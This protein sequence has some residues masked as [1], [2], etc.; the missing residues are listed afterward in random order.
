MY[1]HI[2]EYPAAIDQKLKP[3]RVS[4]PAERAKQFDSPEFAR[5]DFFLCPCVT[6]IESPHKTQLNGGSPLTNDFHH[7]C[8]FGQIKRDRLFAEDGLPCPSGHFDQSRVCIGRSYNHDRIDA[9]MRNGT[10]NFGVG[11]LCAGKNF[12]S[13]RR[14]RAR[15]SDCDHLHL[16]EA[17]NIPQMCFAHPA[18]ADESDANCFPACHSLVMQRL[19]TDLYR[20]SG[21]PTF[22]CGYSDSQ[23]LERIE[24][25]WRRCNTVGHTSKEGLE[26][27]TE[28]RSE[29]IHKEMVMVHLISRFRIVP[30]RCLRFRLD[31]DLAI[32]PKNFRHDIVA[33]DCP[34]R[35]LY[36]ADRA[37]F[38]SQQRCRS[39][40]IPE[41]GGVF[42]E[43]RR[44]PGVDFGD[45]SDQEPGQVEFMNRLIDKNPATFRK[46]FF[47]RRTGV[48]ADRAELVN[49]S[50]RSRCDSPLRFGVSRIKTSLKSDLKWHPVR[51]HDLKRLLR[52][53]QFE[54]HRFFAK[55]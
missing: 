36:H 35:I 14:F 17:G 45:F 51:M 32:R 16:R 18:K 28:R 40:G 39:V 38:E 52:P 37:V 5:I 3:W 10:F 42:T 21:L 4:V 26:F 27:R 1:R 8:R 15:V 12:P 41:C 46:V 43:A 47:R 13:L 22:C 44:T 20:L 6:G 50:Q 30:N 19:S 29:S 2:Q 48:P 9:R 24:R 25:I 49:P 11:N 33:I 23:R 34:A 55:I 31:N 53:L 7:T 54:G